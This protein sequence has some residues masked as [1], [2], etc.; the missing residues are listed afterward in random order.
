MI[1]VLDN[2]TGEQK[3]I[4]DDSVLPDLVASGA[5]SIPDK[6]YEFVDDIGKKFAVPAK[7]FAEAVKA[8][9]KFRDTNTVE[10]EKL[11]AK[12]GNSEGKALGL[13]LARGLT[14]GLSDVALEKTGLASEEALREI[15]NRNPM[16]SAAGEITG[17]I[18]PMFLSGGAGM[19]GK[20]AVSTML[21]KGAAK[22]A[23][24]LAAKKGLINSAMA[25]S[26]AGLTAGVA[27]MAGK[28]AAQNINSNL[29]KGVVAL[30]AE[31]AIEGGVAG[32]GNVISEVELGNAE[33][34]AETLLANVGTGA[35]IGAGF[36]AGIAGGT[37]Y[38]SKVSRGAQKQIQEKIIQQID[39]DD[40]L[41]EAARK[42][43]NDADAME[44]GILA[45][46][47]PEIQRIKMEYPE[48]PITEGME[49]ALKPIKQVEDY[50]FDA[51]TLQGEAIRRNAKE[52]EEYVATNVDEIFSGAKVASAEETGD[53]IRQTFFTKIN[54][55]WES[56]KAFYNDLM[57][58]F[59]NAPVS[60]A[61]RT[62]L[63]NIIRNS[64]AFRVG[65]EGSEIKRVL[66]IVDDKKEL[67]AR[68][69]EELQT[70]GLNKRQ[71]N[72]ILKS[73]KISSGLNKELNN[74]GINLRE[75]NNILA[76]HAKELPAKELTLKQVKSLQKDI[77]A[78]IKMTTGEERQ[79][80]RETYNQLR[81]M[82]D[83]II[84]ES[85]GNSAAAQKI[86]KGLDA[87]ND[88]YKRAFAAKDEIAELLGI[89]GADL[90]TVL[91]NLEKK[92]AIDIDKRFLNLKKTDKAFETMNK[93]PELGKLVLAN[94]QSTLL[95]KHI[96]NGGYNW[97]GLKKDILK[98]T[99]EERALYFGGNKAQEKKL[100]DMVT[101]YE[102]R[103]K[104]MNPSGT[105]V[106]KE[107][108]DMLSPKKMT[109]NWI[110][111]EVYKGDK[112]FIGKTINK[113]M[114]VLS[115]VERSANRTKN[116]ISSSVSAFFKAA[117]VGVA[118]G[119]LTSFS[120]RELK[121][122]EK[123]YELAQS[124]PEALLDSFTRKNKDLIEAAPETANALQQRII[125][126]VQFL[127]SKTPKRDQTYIGEDL[128]PSRSELIKFNDYMEAVENPKV[129]FNQLKEGYIN[130]NS[131]EVLRTVYPRIHESIQAEVL[132]K[133]P[134]NLTR[135][136]KIQL[137]PL[138]GSQITP[139]MDYKN[140]MR[141]QGKT[142][143]SAAATQQASQEM[144]KV[145]MGAAQ[146]MKSSER[147]QTGLA[148]TLNRT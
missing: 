27:G 91:E 138:L 101:L 69:S 68:H 112:S 61:K 38:I 123:N 148:K 145:P 115:G 141:L 139:A 119:T 120:D 140:L 20:A 102:K 22:E 87:A 132:A 30:T 41:K 51:P 121:K 28:R 8:G 88:D 125:A 147:T 62:E 17:N 18:A 12:Y 79:L 3:T 77:G 21:A 86:I 13:S 63:S 130:P 114:P 52:L 94:R 11:E 66:G 54:E 109:Q 26:P 146:N 134:K 25:Y 110:L 96:V 72:E 80:L 117:P 90:D 9:W 99:D 2:A 135:Q 31:G 42:R 7:G 100:L 105:D 93:Y 16:T 49:S 116:N 23:A 29:V 108:R 107:F 84:R 48:A 14:L 81:T 6:E 129:I 57:G 40:A 58:E 43:F 113:V 128:Q 89:K 78:K 122:A 133:I 56:G 15:K 95:K 92:S 143:D 65:G 73:D 118:V 45:L 111:S 127:Q 106:R 74:A 71:V 103:P 131:L 1:Q 142:Q 46:K 55:P 144:N 19:V 104:T 24:E 35:L 97:S 32:L 76:R 126:G 75:L 44:E 4:E 64:D 5:V 67:L 136:Q 83:S 60:Q 82:Q 137:Q 59:G 53:L 47:D 124:D 70:L 10:D 33:F 85:V 36:G 98:M 50:L 34:N 39:G 37:H